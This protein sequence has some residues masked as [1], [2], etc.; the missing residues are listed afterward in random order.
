MRKVCNCFAQLDL[1]SLVVVVSQKSCLWM[2]AP[3]PGHL[4][5]NLLPCHDL[6][7]PGWGQWDASDCPWLHVAGMCSVEVFSGVPQFCN[8]WTGVTGMEGF[9]PLPAVNFS[10]GLSAKWDLFFFLFPQFVYFPEHTDFWHGGPVGCCRCWEG[11]APGQSFVGTR[12]C[13]QQD[14]ISVSYHRASGAGMVVSYSRC[15]EIWQLVQPRVNGNA[16]GT[17]ICVNI[18]I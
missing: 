17:T 1:Q 18:D 15:Q 5:A 7:S 12:P 6:L 8:G 3:K 10:T 14:D 4:S 9:V 13:P 16:A 2:P 11:L